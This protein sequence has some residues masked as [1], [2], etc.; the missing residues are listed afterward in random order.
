MAKEE[1]REVED[2]TTEVRRNPRAD[3]R[4]AV[5]GNRRAGILGGNV[6]V[7]TQERWHKSQRYNGD[8]GG[9]GEIAKAAAGPPHSI[10]PKRPGAT[11]AL[12]QRHRSLPVSGQAQ[13]RPLH[14]RRN[15]RAD[16]NSAF[17]VIRETLASALY[18]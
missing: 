16:G 11:A 8:L 4:S 5:P 13:D 9:A 15:P 2:P 14:G 18:G 10:N 3:Q 12:R 1:R 17:G 6:G 7:Q